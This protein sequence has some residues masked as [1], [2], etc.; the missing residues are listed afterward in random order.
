MTRTQYGLFQ[1]AVAFIN[2]KSDKKWGNAQLCVFDVLV[3][4]VPFEDRI[5]LLEQLRGKK[6]IRVVDYVKCTSAAHLE[7]YLVNVLNKNGEGVILREPRSMYEKGRSQSMKKV[8]K[9]LDVEVKVL[10]PKYPFG[11]ECVQYVI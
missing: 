4:D 11:L 1:D 10:E 7:E 2:N 9:Y 3:P 8:K 6:N 5:Q